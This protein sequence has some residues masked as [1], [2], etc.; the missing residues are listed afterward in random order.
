M[1]LLEKAEGLATTQAEFHHAAGH[2]ALRRESGGR[3]GSDLPQRR[4]RRSSRL[5]GQIVIGTDSHTCMAGVLGCFAFGVGS[6]DMANAVVHQR[7]SHPRT[8]D[9][10]LCL[11]RAGNVRTSLPRM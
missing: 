9:R 5:P 10:A 6:T 1:G 2:Q 7:H 3:L 11:D 4:R 8:R